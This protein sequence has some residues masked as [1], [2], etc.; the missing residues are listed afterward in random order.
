MEAWIRYMAGVNPQTASALMR[1]IDQRMAEG[2]SHLHLMISSPGGSVFHG[3]SIHNFLRSVGIQVSTYNFGSVDS[4]GVVIFCAGSHR[5][6]VPS[7]RFH[8]HGVKLNFRGELSFDEKALEEHLKLMATDY[9]NIAKVIADTTGQSVKKVVADMN[10]QTS[11]M[12]TD[13][14]KYGLVHEVRNQFVPAQAGMTVI[15]EDATS[16]SYQPPP[17]QSDLVSAEAVTGSERG[18]TEG[19]IGMVTSRPIASS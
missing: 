16:F 6:C 19:G 10:K 11:L 2:M 5:V 14:E 1:A 8:I 3:L 15:Y 17:R 18:T 12:P 7:S 4:I 13:A 9:D